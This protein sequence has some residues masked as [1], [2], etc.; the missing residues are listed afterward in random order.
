MASLRRRESD[1]LIGLSRRRD[2]ADR[3]YLVVVGARKPSA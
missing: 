3:D 1:V 2:P